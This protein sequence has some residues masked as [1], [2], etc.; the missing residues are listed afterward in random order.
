MKYFLIEKNEEVS[1]FK[2]TKESHKSFKEKDVK[3]VGVF[4][5]EDYANIW[6]DFYNR[7]I[8]GKEL[9]LKLKL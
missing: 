5:R 9:R 6:C 7:K 2:T 4:G 3:V 1:I 8:S